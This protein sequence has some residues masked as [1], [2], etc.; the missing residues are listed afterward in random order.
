MHYSVQNGKGT[1][2]MAEEVQISYGCQTTL[3]EVQGM[4]HVLAVSKII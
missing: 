2:E 3:I 4:K 1:C